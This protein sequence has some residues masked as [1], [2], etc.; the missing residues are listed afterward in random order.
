MRYTA[1]SAFQMPADHRSALFEPAHH[2]LYPQAPCFYIPA[3]VWLLFL[4]YRGERRHLNHRLQ[5]YLPSAVIISMIAVQARSKISSASGAKSTPYVSATRNHFFETSATRLRPS[6]ISY[7]C[8]RILPC[9]SS[10]ST[11]TW[12][13]GIPLR[14][15]AISWSMKMR[16]MMDGAAWL[17]V[18]RKGSAVG[19]WMGGAV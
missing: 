3:F 2:Q 8:S 5:Y 7:S 1:V 13:E 18:R 11:F 19:N 10:A 12:R 15:K 14:R 6:W 9:A 4:Q 16:S 17:R